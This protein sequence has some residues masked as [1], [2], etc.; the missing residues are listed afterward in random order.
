MRAM[1]A[2]LWDFDGTIVDTE[3][4][5]MR[6]EGDLVRSHGGEYTME[7]AHSLVGG[8]LAS[9][10]AAIAE[11]LPGRPLEPDAIA[12]LL[13]QRVVDAIAGA[14]LAYKPGVVE[15][16]AELADAGVPCA[17]VSTSGR[18]LL[19]AAVARMPRH[20][21]AVIVGSEDTAV[22][23]PDP[24]AYLTALRAL[25]VDAHDALVIEDSVVGTEAGNA[26]GAV[27]LAVPDQ[28]PVPE[29]PHRLVVESLAGITVD[30]L[31]E[32][33]REQR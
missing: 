20:P 32:I 12:E 8:N 19:E 7:F 17:L 5:W 30:D 14:P 27:V 24:E 21:F 9:T 29:R 4:V 22:Y 26:A 13:F 15:L 25:G 1:Q 3:T 11:L 16:L 23:K 18:S 28:V 2:V 10:S 31:R 6:V 33:W